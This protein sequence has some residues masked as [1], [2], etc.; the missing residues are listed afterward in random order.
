MTETEILKRESTPDTRNSGRSKFFWYAGIFMLVYVVMAFGLAALEQPHRH[1]R[2]TRI[3]VILHSVVALSWLVLFIVQSR[4]VHVG[5]IRAHKRNAWIGSTLAVLITVQAIHLTYVWGDA[6][7]LIAESRDAIVFAALFFAAIWAAQKN[8]FD[9]HTRLMF[10]AGLNLINPAQIRLTFAL[11]WPIPMAVVLGLIAWIV[12]PLV[13][14][15]VTQRSVHRASIVGI[16]VTVL[17]FFLVLAIVFSPFIETI[18]NWF[19]PA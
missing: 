10:I 19:Y 9:V 15:L 16:A 1:E 6:V 4:L 17:S 2:Y 3:E 12:P 5:A 18:G 7:R 8:K 11:G 13:Y 14:D